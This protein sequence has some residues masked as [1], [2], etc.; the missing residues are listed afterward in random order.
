MDWC[1]LKNKK[2]IYQ[3]QVRSYLK[4]DLHIQPKQPDFARQCN[5]K[6]E[7]KQDVTIDISMKHRIALKQG[8]M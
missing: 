4:A 7:L 8:E 1:S 3:L 5:F 2:K 6:F